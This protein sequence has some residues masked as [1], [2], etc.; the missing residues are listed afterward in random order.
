MPLTSL[1]TALTAAADDDERACMAALIELAHLPPEAVAGVRRVAL[2]LARNVRELRLGAGGLDALA[3]RF[4]LGSTEG[5]ALMLLAEALLRIPDHATV[6]RLL[7]D[8]LPRGRW[9][10][11]LQPT[12]DRRTQWALK[13]LA[14]ASAMQSGPSP[15]PERAM[16]RWADS[17]QRALARPLIRH[18]AARALQALGRQFV[19]GQTIEEALTR[20]AELSA[21][22]YRFSFDMLGEAAVTM[23]DALRYTAAYE[24]AIH[25]VGQAAAGVKSTDPTAR[26]GVS[27]K[28]SALHPRFERSQRERVLSEMVPRVSALFRMA[29]R[30]GVSLTI[31]AEESHRLDLT[32]DVLQAVAADPELAGFN[33]IGIAVQAY[34]KRAPQVIDWLAA[35][36]RTHAQRFMVRLVKGAYWDA[37]IK[38]AQV[39]GLRTY[40]VYTRKAFTDT[41]YLACAR[42]LLEATDVLYPQFATQNAHTV[43]AIYA[44]GRNKPYEYQCL[45]GMGQAL[46]DQ[47]V[48]K[49]PG[50]NLQ[51]DFGDDFEEYTLRSCRIYAPV[52]TH[53]TLLAYLVRR[54]LENGA[55][56][57]FVNRVLAP[58]VPLETLVADPVA[59]A[60]E[61]RTQAHP[62]IVPPPE[63][64]APQRRN[65]V[66]LD[67]SHEHTLTLFEEALAESE[68][69]T[70]VALPLV[71]GQAL[72]GPHR[73]VHNPARL[74]EVVGV[75]ID[76]PFT[77]VDDAVGCALAAAAQWSATTVDTRA[78]SLERAASLL[79]ARQFEFMA[80][81]VREA[82]KTWGSAMAEVRE[83]IDFLRYYA[84]QAREVL[85]QASARGPLV[86]ISPWNFPLAIF[87]GQVSA[88]LMAG[89]TVLAKPAEQTPLV[90][91]HAVRLL[92]E[93]GVPADVLQL[94]PGAGE[95]L[96]AA[97]VA[98]PRV[99]GVLFT[100]SLAVARE[101]A[102]TLA[103]REDEP[104]FIAETG[105]INAMIVDSSALPEQVV[106][107]V[108]TSAFDSAGQRCSALRVLC[109]QNEIA[110]RVLGLLK[111][112]MD[113]LVVGDP[114][115]ISTDIGPVIDDAAQMNLLGAIDALKSTARG[116]HQARVTAHID[117]STFV[118]PTLAEVE[119]VQNVKTEV[120]GPV[121]HV[122]RF[123]A[124][125]LDSLID[126]INASGYGLTH[127][128][129]SRI[130]S[131]VQHIAARI[132]AGNIYVNRN[133]IGAVVGVQPF[134][135]EGMSGTGPKAGGPAYLRALVRAGAQ[136]LFATAPT[137]PPPAL[138]RLL[139]A[140]LPALS[141]AARARLTERVAL[142]SARSPL[143]HVF[144]LPGPTGE[145]NTLS[146]APRG[147]VACLAEELEPLAQLCAAALACGNR[148]V[149]PS[150]PAGRALAAILADQAILHPDPSA[151]EL[152]S[153]LI[154][155]GPPH[156]ARELRQRLSQRNGALVTFIHADPDP[157]D[158]TRLVVE[159]CVS[160]NTTAWGGNAGLL[161]EGP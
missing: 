64:F 77:A 34:N 79:Q 60:S 122:V 137:T 151:H 130:E 45:Y 141:A 127:G 37:E 42:K 142:Y 1:R 22:G 96:G 23:P 126:A 107:D 88:A 97:L 18:A 161:S 85:P 89:N 67:F 46:Y 143:H 128:I 73:T 101:I 52:G 105:G 12:D 134:G 38:R 15:A 47:V 6:E 55:N 116:C 78:A 95:T 14:W 136:P 139:D 75:V 30:F 28:L 93:A 102:Q 103:Q 9:L 72:H 145:R 29:R 31:D 106:A 76:T 138:Q 3:Q 91:T 104:L 36:A 152:I 4:P 16:A 110:D 74:S 148:V 84:A 155:A 40:P 70:H 115:H 118:P 109:L 90:A 24:H 8:Q 157:I 149:L 66:G 153:T 94:L 7:R 131:T 129:H 54:L 124:E 146:Y 121:L 154:F 32:L 21:R 114:R 35:L 17:A 98:D 132:R 135:G 100:G 123:A 147:F 71:G 159:R 160:I 50:A 99:A 61:Q 20:S 63:L 51:E 41:A 43:A 133:M 11:A 62:P 156:T 53:E 108:L 113:E 111:G 2:T 59:Q 19:L 144:E 140:P 87:V 44:M 86:A 27:I 13:G 10:D 48:G 125:D 120:F 80:L 158:L 26:P 119:R 56:S 117:H 82:G 65:S 39:L 25:R 150:T 112:A 5:Q 58:E 33:G 81:L 83:A 69:T 68:S 49:D 92:H 57:S